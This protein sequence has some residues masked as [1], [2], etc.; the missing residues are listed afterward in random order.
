[1]NNIAIAG[2]FRDASSIY[3][4]SALEKFSFCYYF[5]PETK[6]TRAV[7]LNRPHF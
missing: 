1:L 2:T 7:Q 4:K 3:I 6:K 5:L